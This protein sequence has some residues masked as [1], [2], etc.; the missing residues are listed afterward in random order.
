MTS[1]SSLLRLQ[2]LVWWHH[3]L[4]K[5]CY[6]IRGILYFSYL[7]LRETRLINHSLKQHYHPNITAQIPTLWRQPVPRRSP[8]P[9]PNEARS[10]RRPTGPT[11]RRDTA[12]LADETGCPSPR[13]QCSCGSSAIRQG[14][15]RRP[16]AFWRSVA[17]GRESSEATPN[18][19]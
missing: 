15:C 17:R 4:N 11:Y 9:T 8:L 1:P 18:L 16:T 6:F 19:S 2:Q 10:R 5:V 14:R 3:N 7:G 13:V 12:S